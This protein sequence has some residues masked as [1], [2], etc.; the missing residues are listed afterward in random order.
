MQV[1]FHQLELRY[2]SLRR[3][4]AEQERKL[5]GS[6]ASTGQQS[7]VVVVSAEQSGRYVLIDGYKR[8]RALK[9]LG[10]DTVRA[11]LWDVSERDALIVEHH[12]HRGESPSALE[13]GWLLQELHEGFG[14]SVSELS[15]RFDRSSSWVS[16]RLSLVKQLPESVQEQVRCGQI[17]PHAAMKYLAPLARANRADCIRLVE[18]T[19]PR[20]VSTRQMERLYTAYM[21]GDD[22]AR[23]WVLEQ[24]WLFLEAERERSEHPRA[25]TTPAEALVDDLR[26]LGTVSRRCVRRLKQ[27]LA[28]Q[29]LPFEKQRAQRAW[30]A[31]HSEL[32]ALSERC[33]GDLADAGPSP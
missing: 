30:R 13:Q 14:L 25:E 4:S 18:A 1:E 27:G 19:R 33:E 26:I 21:S 31:A 32:T 2:E 10:R 12:M 29:L 3:T 28:A 7:T 24:P 15:V 6:L 5:L 16:R 17:V 20:R 23:Q 9:R 8:V 11:S 22:T